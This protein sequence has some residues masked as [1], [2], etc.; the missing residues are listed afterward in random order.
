LSIIAFEGSKEKC[1]SF[2]KGYEKITMLWEMLCVKGLIELPPL[3]GK[4]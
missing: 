1:F 2:M 3:A 4:I